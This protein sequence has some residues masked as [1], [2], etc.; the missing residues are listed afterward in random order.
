MEAERGRLECQGAARAKSPEGDFVRPGLFG[1]NR[2][3]PPEEGWNVLVRVQVR[4]DGGYGRQGR[5]L[6]TL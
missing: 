5:L 4:G 6:R 1:E 2:A 3:E